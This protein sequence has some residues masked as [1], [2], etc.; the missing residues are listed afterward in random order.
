MANYDTPGLL[1][2]SGVLYDAPTLPQPIRKRM[3]KPKLALSTLTNDQIITLA[4]N[5]KTAMTGNANFT[6]PNPT[7]ASVTTLITTATTGLA[8]F[9]TAKTALDNAM[10]T[11]DNAMATLRAA[12][13]QLAAYVENVTAGDKTKIET[14]GMSTRAPGAALGPMP[15]VAH[16]DVTAGD[17]DGSLDAAWDNVK[18]AGSYEIQTSVDPVSGTSWG[19]KQVANKSSA[20]LEGFTSGNR[21]WVR[22]RAVGADNAAG[23]W[24]DPAVKTV[25]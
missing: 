2:D 16:L 6:T 22:V 13:N 8:G 19:F 23:P 9:V 5:I 11:R 15:Q 24:S 17:F 4:T 25:P 20:T 10:N 7:L 1:Y 3:A 21:I 12:L 18:G 14:A